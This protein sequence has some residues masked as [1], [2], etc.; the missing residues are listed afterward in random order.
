MRKTWRDHWRLILLIIA[1]GGGVLVGTVVLLFQH[2]PGWY[3]PLRIVG[4]DE[5]QAV[6]YDLTHTL[7]NF[8]LTL[9][10]ATGPFEY[11]ISEQQINAWLAI[12]EEIWPLSREWLPAGLSDPAISLEEGEVRLAVTYR[13][14]SLK[15]VASIGFHIEGDSEGVLVQLTDIAG[16]SLPVPK[17]WARDELAK[18]DRG[19][20]PAGRVTRYQYSG[21]AMPSLIDLMTEAEFPNEWVWQNG[22]I[23]FR[24]AQL[25]VEKGAVVLTIEPL[26]RQVDKRRSTQPP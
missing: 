10:A 23:P 2:I 18:L 20:W 22:K 8:T 15:T 5:I 25:T 19:K 16:G 11:R 13:D 3:R 26:P 4:Q 9:D 17:S 7:D 14:G 12:R 1:A 6:Q 21:R 24:I